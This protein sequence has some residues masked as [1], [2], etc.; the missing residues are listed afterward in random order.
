MSDYLKTAREFYGRLIIIAGSTTEVNKDVKD[1]KNGNIK[2][3]DF[4][5]KYGLK[6]K[7]GSTEGA[8][9]RTYRYLQT[10]TNP[11]E[12]QRGLE[13]QNSWIPPKVKQLPTHITTPVITSNWASIMLRKF[14][15]E[16]SDEKILNLPYKEFCAVGFYLHVEPITFPELLENPYPVLKNCGNIIKSLNSFFSATFTDKWFVESDKFPICI[17]IRVF[18]V[19]QDGTEFC[20][21]SGYIDFKGWYET[22]INMLN[23]YFSKAIDMENWY[24]DNPTLWLIQYLCIDSK[25]FSRTRFKREQ[26]YRSSLYLNY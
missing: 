2:Y 14:T 11:I 25:M 26:G 8:I 1:L 7:R 10:S 19:D 6:T 13:L 18:F 22:I 17:R 23:K 9:R 15:P 24:E 4:K 16:F 20:F 5:K 21:Q 3:S 12:K